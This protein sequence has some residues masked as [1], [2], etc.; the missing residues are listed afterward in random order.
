M[1]SL[2]KPNVTVCFKMEEDIDMQAEE[3]TPL[4]RDGRFHINF[5]GNNH[6]ISNLKCTQGKFPELLRTV[7]RQLQ[8][9]DFQECG[10]Q[11]LPDTHRGYCRIYPLTGLRIPKSAI[12]VINGT[13]NQVENGRD[14][15]STG[16]VGGIVG[17]MRVSRISEC[18]ARS[19]SRANGVQ[20]DWQ[21]S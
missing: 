1:G 13:F 10:N 18:S 8:E 5:D 6:T 11:R 12:H 14:H 7:S 20:A 4:N 3:W 16:S 15:W 21:A 2:L 19:T 9:R 17:D